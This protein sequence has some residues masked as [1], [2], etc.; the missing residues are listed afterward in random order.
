MNNLPRPNIYQRINDVMK[1][2]KY[3]QKDSSISGGGANYKAVSHDQVVSVVRQAMVDHGIMIFPSQKSGEFLIKRDLAAVPPV[4]MGLYSGTYDINFVNIDHG[5]D[6][7]TVTIEAHA[8]DNGD[9]APG[10]ALSYAVKSAV[11]KVFSL[12]TGENDE[13]RVE[14]QNFDY[15]TNEQQGTLYELMVDPATNQL[16]N[17]AQKVARAFKFQQISEIKASKYEDI[18]K[19]VS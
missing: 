1:A 18:L 15:I 14:E 7:V 19:A 8:N 12:E 3:V 16:N 2:V 4:K 5:E 9:K 17:K 11:L 13:S 6:K 10:K